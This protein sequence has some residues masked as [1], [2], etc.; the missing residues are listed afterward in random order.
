MRELVHRRVS[1]RVRLGH[2]RNRLVD[3]LGVQQRLPVDVAFNAEFVGRQA[4]FFKRFVAFGERRGGTEPR[5]RAYQR[6][7][8]RYSPEPSR[9]P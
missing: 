1:L 8:S 7:D 5:Q 2:R 4:F 9:H 3:P 6:R